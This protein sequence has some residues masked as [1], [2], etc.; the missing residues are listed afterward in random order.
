M[1]NITPLDCWMEI[2]DEI[3]SANFNYLL[4]NGPR[5]R[6]RILDDFADSQFIFRTSMATLYHEH[7]RRRVDV[8]RRIRADHPGI[9]LHPLILD[10]RDYCG[11]GP[12]DPEFL[13]A[14]EE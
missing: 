3:E 12:E 11:R 8:R 4:V 9:A 14:D 1:K 5:A 7:V 2:R 10:M 6:S 13:V